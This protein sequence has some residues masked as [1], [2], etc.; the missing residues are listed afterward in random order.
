L[1]HWALSSKA[2]RR[3]VVKY[4]IIPRRI[5]PAVCAIVLLLL[6]GGATTLTAGCDTEVSTAVLG[7]VQELTYTL[8]DAVFLSIENQL[9]NGSADVSTTT[10][11]TVTTSSGT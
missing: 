7:G 9:E 6:S 5:G 1:K 3:T 2:K 4:N 11:T 10:D 8:V